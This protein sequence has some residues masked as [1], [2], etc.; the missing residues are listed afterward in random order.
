MPAGNQSLQQYIPTVNTTQSAT[1]YKANIDSDTSIVG[2]PAGMFYVYPQTPASMSVNID[3]GFT[4]NNV[5][6]GLVLNNGAAAATLL[7]TA[8]G[9][10]TYNGTIYYDTVANTFGVV[11]SPLGTAPILPEMI[12]QIPLSIAN[13]SSSTVTIQAANLIDARWVNFAPLGKSATIGTNQSYNAFGASRVDLILVY[14]AA[15]TVT[16]TNLQMGVPVLIRAE[17]SGGS[18]FVI[19][20]AASSPAGTAFAVFGDSGGSSTNLTTTGLS[21]AAAGIHD[22]ILCNPAS[23]SYQLQ[24][25]IG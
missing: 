25:V 16:L 7:L 18:P 21:I 3:K 5:G 11:Y 19:K 20:I 2:N 12:S 8:P 15:L 13:I 17:N 23:G 24:G 14:T 4:Y 9:S 10:S 22:F 1:A 6:T